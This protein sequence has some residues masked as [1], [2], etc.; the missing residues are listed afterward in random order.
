MIIAKNLMC[1]IVLLAAVTP[2]LA[3]PPP[4]PPADDPV[5]PWTRGV[6]VA[7]VSAVEGR[8]TI[9]TY[10]LANPESPDGKRV[11]FFASRH[12]AGYVGDIVVLDRASGR[13]TVL[14]E[15]VHTEDAH[16]AACQQWL[17]GGRRVAWHEVVDGR[18][19]VVAVDVESKARTIVAQD[20]QVGFGQAGGDLL[21]LYGCHWNPGPHRHLEIWDART[22]RISRPVEIERVEAKYGEWLEKAFGGKRTSIFFPVLSP[23]SRRVFFKMA[24]G[25]GGDKYM[26]KDA[27]QRLGLVCYDLERSAFVWQHVKWGHPAWHPDSRRILE[28][29][30]ILYDTDTGRATRIPD[31]PTPK[32]SH[33]SMSGDGQLIVTDG[34]SGPYGG[35]EKEWGVFVGDARGGKWTL[36]HSFDQSRGARS[37][38]RNDPHPAFSADGTRI[39]FNV[40]DG[41]FTRLMVAERR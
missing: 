20:R 24:A 5:A 10:Y 28:V 34:L 2:I 16:R 7:P 4:S 32:G 13:E 21:P 22:G 6:R 19:R 11:V 27:S 30:N 31:L 40:S 29:G 3:D 8:H 26:A 18:W 23:D 1:L 39:Y 33:P 25:K 17:S 36:I 41:P 38:R 14:A 12:P 15:N 37:W 35:K 9:H